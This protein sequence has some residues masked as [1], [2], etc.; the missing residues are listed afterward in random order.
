MGVPDSLEG[1]DETQTPNPTKTSPE[2]PNG[3]DEITGE[4]PYVWPKSRVVP[5]HYPHPVTGKM[6][7]GK[8]K[9]IGK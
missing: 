9:G 7:K 3:P 1:E 6:W 4:P 8:V 2:D 5:F